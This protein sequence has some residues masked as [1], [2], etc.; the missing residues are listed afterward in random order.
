MVQLLLSRGALLDLPIEKWEIFLDR[1]R[2]SL[3][4]ENVQR[5][6]YFQENQEEWFARS[7]KARRKSESTSDAESEIDSEVLSESGS[8]AETS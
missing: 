3:H 7:E 5:L 4:K 1:T 2:K 8:E 6:R